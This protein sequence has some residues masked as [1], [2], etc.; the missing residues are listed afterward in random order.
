M[1]F[2]HRTNIM[3]VTDA[4]VINRLVHPKVFEKIGMQSATFVSG[5][6]QFVTR[7]GALVK[8]APERTVANGILKREF[9]LPEGRLTI[10]RDGIEILIEIFKRPKNSADTGGE[11]KVLRCA[12][13]DRLLDGSDKTNPLSAF[14]NTHEATNLRP[15]PD[16]KV[17]ELSIYCYDPDN[18]LPEGEMREFIMN[19]DGHLFKNFDAEDFFRLW[20]KAFESSNMA[21]WQPAPP[22]KSVARHFV[23]TAGVVLTEQGYHRMDAVTGWYNALMFFLDK[24]KFV[25]TYGEHSAAFGALQ[26]ALKRMEER[27]GRR[28]NLRERAWVV[29]AQNVPA[30]YL[31]EKLKLGIRWINSPTYTEYVCRIHKDLNRFSP[32]PV[33][34]TITLPNL[35]GK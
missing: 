18:Y 27:V 24:L 12:M 15:H 13:R 26:K 9:V 17:A 28:L 22:I 31:P 5:Q 33:V 3:G 21:P 20:S 32:D 4:D 23:E 2:E 8:V 7:R 16:F 29:A 35:F 25:F 1:K 6:L 14:P 10:E 11:L 30:C 34:S 19:V